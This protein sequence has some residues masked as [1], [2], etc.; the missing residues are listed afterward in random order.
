MQSQVMMTIPEYAQSSS[1][2]QKNLIISTNPDNDDIKKSEILSMKNTGSSQTPKSPRPEAFQKY[3]RGGFSNQS[4][5]NIREL[6]NRTERIKKSL[7]NRILVLRQNFELK[8]LS[9]EKKLKDLQTERELRSQ[10]I[11]E[12]LQRNAS[13]LLERDTKNNEE[14]M[15]KTEHIREY[16]ASKE[17]IQD[18]FI[19]DTLKKYESQEIKVKNKINEELFDKI[20][21]AKGMSKNLINERNDLEQQKIEK[22]FVKYIKKRGKI[23][24]NKKKVEIAKTYEIQLRKNRENIKA[25]DVKKRLKEHEIE[26]QKRNENIEKK[27]F[28]S[29][30]KAIEKKETLTKMKVYHSDLEGLASDRINDIQENYNE[31]KMKL[32]R[33]HIEMVKKIDEFRVMKS[34]DKRNVLK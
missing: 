32:L 14:Y 7:E 22:D 15:K 18:D 13:S 8:K 9:Q 33:E 34:P 29:T 30:L 4:P 6:D 10:K 28:E 12:K 25:E 23:F 16:M 31:Y 21:K 3:S 24:E 1:S 17:R 20:S 27:V 19:R 26:I 5:T 11:L 2:V